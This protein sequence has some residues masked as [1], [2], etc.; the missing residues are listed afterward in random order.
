VKMLGYQPFEVLR[1]QMRRARGFIFAAEEDFGIVPVEA[2]ACGTP[3]IALGRGGALETVIAGRSG[4][5][6]DEQTPESLIAGIEAFERRADWDQKAICA[7]ARRFS[8]ERFRLEF[9]AVVNQQWA[10][11]DAERSRPM[12]SKPGDGEAFP[13]SRRIDLPIAPAPE[14]PEPAA[15]ELI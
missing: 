10:K 6:F 7:S 9:S 8:V 11:F 14:L 4:V 5:F 2:M 13:P 12:G 15:A 1:D 3:V